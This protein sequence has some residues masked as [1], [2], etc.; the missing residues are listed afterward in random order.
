MRGF[1]SVLLA[2]LV[3]TVLSPM[4]SMFAQAPPNCGDLPDHDHLRAAL[5]PI[6]KEGK[7]GHGGLDTQEW[8]AVVNRD[9]VVCA[10]VYSGTELTDQWPGSRMISAEKANTANAFSAPDYALSTANVYWPA[11]PGQ[12]L[13]GINTTNPPNAQAAF[14]DATAFGQKNDPMVGKQVGGV[15]VFGGGLALYSQKGKIVGGLGASGNTACADHVIA[16]KLRHQLNLD[17]VPMGPSPD[18]ND[19]MILDIQNGNSASG[20]GHPR[21]KGGSPSESIIRALSKNYPTRSAK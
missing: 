21:C 20:F 1:Q 16:W 10:V 2:I 8:A 5:Q 11:Q 6:V 9:G 18:Q 7:K 17:A 15:V 19:N 4:Q 13:Y 3:F 14:G 12:G